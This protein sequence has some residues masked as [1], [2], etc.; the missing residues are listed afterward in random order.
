MDEFVHNYF[1]FQ[2]GYNFT[3]HQKRFRF[4]KSLLEKE[5][6]IVLQDNKTD[7][8]SPENIEKSLKKLSEVK[9]KFLLSFDNNKRQLMRIKEIAQ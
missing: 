8:V 1:A 3:Q 4:S 9:E 7:S 6:S 2:I 5:V